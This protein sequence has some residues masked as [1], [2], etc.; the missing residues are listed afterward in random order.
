MMMN[1]KGHLYV[2]CKMFFHKHFETYMW[3]W[4]DNQIQ[5]IQRQ[6]ETYALDFAHKSICIEDV[7]GLGTAKKVNLRR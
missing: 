2:K 3:L 5:N 7:F 1:F 6:F 4:K